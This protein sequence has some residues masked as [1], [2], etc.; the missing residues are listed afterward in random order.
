[1]YYIIYII[2]SSLLLDT[3]GLEGGPVLGRADGLLE[4]GGDLLCLILG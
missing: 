1:M 4:V 3:S 2:I